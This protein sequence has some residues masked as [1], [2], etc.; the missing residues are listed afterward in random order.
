MLKARK[1]T[2]LSLSFKSVMRKSLAVKGAVL[3]LVATFIAI[4]SYIESLSSK[5]NECL[6]SEP[7]EVFLSMLASICLCYIGKAEGN[8]KYYAIVLPDK[9]K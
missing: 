5:R 4:I 8:N 6:F 2:I 3:L 9:Y 7:E 1:K